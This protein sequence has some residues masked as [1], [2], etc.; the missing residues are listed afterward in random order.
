MLKAVARNEKGK[1]VATD[2]LRTAGKPAKIILT[3]ETN[4]LSPRF[5]NVAIVRAKVLDAKGIQV[6]RAGD[7]ISFQISGPGVIAAVDNADHSSHESFQAMQRHAFHGECVAFVR[8]TAASGK[9][10]I[11]ASAGGLKS[12][13]TVI[14]AVK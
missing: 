7:L 12:D 9:I 10:K 2:E 5:E 1:I 3:A 11:S 8:A 6:P 13:S 4:K 14:Q